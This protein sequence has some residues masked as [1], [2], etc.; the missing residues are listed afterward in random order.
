MIFCFDNFL[1]STGFNRFNKP[2]TSTSHQV[3]KQQFVFYSV[4]LH[5]LIG[6]CDGYTKNKRINFL[7]QLLDQFLN[8][9]P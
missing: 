6:P 3:R 4:L 9:V 2:N 8:S 7:R 5:R 1:R